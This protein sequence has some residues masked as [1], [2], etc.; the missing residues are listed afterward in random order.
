M[1]CTLKLKVTMQYVCLKVIFL[2]KFDLMGHIWKSGE[3]EIFATG[4]WEIGNKKLE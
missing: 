4:M 3:W 1:C 2:R